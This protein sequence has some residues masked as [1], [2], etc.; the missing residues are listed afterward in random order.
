MQKKAE[1]VY[2]RNRVRTKEKAEWI[3]FKR[4]YKIILNIF[5][6]LIILSLFFPFI[7][8]S[9]GVVGVLKYS[10]GF[11]SLFSEEYRTSFLQGFIFS[12]NEVGF[13]RLGLILLILTQIAAIWFSWAKEG[14]LLAL[15]YLIASGVALL[16]GISFLSHAFSA[17]KTSSGSIIAK[18]GMGTWLIVIFGIAELIYLV[19]LFVMKKSPKD[20]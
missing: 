14:R 4:D 16:I 6:I 18:A 10:I 7:L 19:K 3:M 20:Y 11:S 17:A 2:N 15:F 5:S 13:I 9:D 12:V 8:A 1:K